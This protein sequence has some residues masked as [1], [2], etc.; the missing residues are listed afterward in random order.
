MSHSYLQDYGILLSM[1]QPQKQVLSAIETFLGYR[2]EIRVASGML[3]A[4]L[5]WGSGMQRDVNI[6]QNKGEMRKSDS[7]GPVIQPTR[8]FNY[9]PTVTTATTNAHL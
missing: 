5:V 7:C 4:S 2:E 8:A 9:M 3:K 6:P 1:L